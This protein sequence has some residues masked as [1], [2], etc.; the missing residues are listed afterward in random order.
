MSK[1]EN[2]EVVIKIDSSTV[3]RVLY[4]VLAGLLLFSILGKIVQPLILIVI[5]FFLALALNPAVSWIAKK[6]PSGSRSAATGVAY[7][8]VVG[9]L[10]LF[11]AMV[12]PPIIRQTIDFV[13]EVPDTIQDVRQNNQTVREFI[14]KYEIEDQVDS[15]T[16][17]LR[18]RVGDLGKPALS[19]A[20]KVGTTLASIV[21]V[22]VLTFM[23][24]VEG[25]AWFDRYIKT[26]KPHKRQ[27]HKELA[28]KMYKVIVGYVNGQ[29]LIAAL[30]GFF[31]TLSLV[32]ASQILNVGVN[33][34]A[35]G[36]IVALFALLPLIGT[37]IGAI[38]VVLSCLV[39]SV[40]LAI[41]MTIF[42]VIYQQIENVT[43]QPYIQSKTSALTPLTVIVSALVG[44]AIGGL[45]GALLAIPAAGCIKVLIDDYFARKAKSVE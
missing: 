29:V 42:F 5:S 3:L 24:L 37:T 40:P 10:T 4:I 38:I 39:V 13:K 33:Y 26:L 17:D 11:F 43:I 6:L 35:L 31:A 45:I 44:V 8:A 20:G 34:V 16:S 21:I 27:R 22:F 9:F 36:G 18:S 19:A 41:I 32:I 2:K 1:N 30:G 7:V 25:P 12:F 15:F 23:M 28:R 14:I